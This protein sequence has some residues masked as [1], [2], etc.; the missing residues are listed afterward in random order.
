MGKNTGSEDAG[1]DRKS[2]MGYDQ[3]AW[4]GLPLRG[5]IAGALTGHLF[6][7][8]SIKGD[9]L[10]A[11]RNLASGPRNRCALMSPVLI[12]LIVAAPQPR[13]AL[14]VELMLQ[15]GT[16]ALAMLILTRRAGHATA[17]SGTTRPNRPQRRRPWRPAPA[18]GCQGQNR[19][20]NSV[21]ELAALRVHRR[22]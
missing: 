7:A 10:S 13:V 15:A 21:V 19:Q 11:S 12:A 22:L 14:G 1:I 18:D 6:V 2:H 3:T 17:D 4:S 16:S 5:A 20:A 8:V 9:L